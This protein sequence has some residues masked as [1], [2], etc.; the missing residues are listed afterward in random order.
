[1]SMREPRTKSVT[2][3]TSALSN[4]LA[5][6]G[7]NGGGGGTEGGG[8]GGGDAGGGGG[9]EGGGRG[10]GGKGGGC[11]GGGE[12][13]AIGGGGDSASHQLVFNAP[14]SVLA[15]TCKHATPNMAVPLPFLLTRGPWNM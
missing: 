11:G 9:V 10:K 8:G 4:S 13:G 14:L 2:V 5:L 6:E 7:G 12:G 1:M 3:A 15:N